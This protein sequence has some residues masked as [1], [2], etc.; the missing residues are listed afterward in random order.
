MHNLK[1]MWPMHGILVRKTSSSVQSYCNINEIPTVESYI[2]LMACV[3]FGIPWDRD[4]ENNNIIIF[5]RN[6]KDL[7]R[8]PHTIAWRK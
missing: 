6:F 7:R 8:L 5:C 4:N 3:S 1:E 2:L